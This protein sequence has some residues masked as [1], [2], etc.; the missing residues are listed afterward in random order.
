MAT[1]DRLKDGEIAKQYYNTFKDE[2]ARLQ[3]K[4]KQLG[5]KSKL[6]VNNGKVELVVALPKLKLMY[7]TVG[8][9][10]RGANKQVAVVRWQ[11]LKRGQR[12][13]SVSIDE[14]CNK[15]GAI[16]DSIIKSALP[17][18]KVSKSLPVE[19]KL[20]MRK[21]TTLFKAMH[22]EAVRVSSKYKKYP[23]GLNFKVE[24]NR[25]GQLTI[26]VLN[27]EYR[28]VGQLF[29]DGKGNDYYNINWEANGK[30][31]SKQYKKTIKDIQDVLLQSNNKL[32]DRD[33]T[34]YKRAKTNNHK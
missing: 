16:H 25:I 11:G 9:V 32:I 20:D 31:F 21:Q 15:V 17:K 12:I 22:D 7:T 19:P 26:K 34:L 27:N 24:G 4:Y 33:I 1:V 28:L 2:S 29:N 5:I 13:E 10:K 18:V 3:A 6:K 8:T 23:V 14:V 30:V